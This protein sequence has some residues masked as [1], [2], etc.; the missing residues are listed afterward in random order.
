MPTLQPGARGVGYTVDMPLLIPVAL[1]FALF[2]LAL[3]MWPVTLWRRARRGH[4]RRRVAPWAVYVRSLM[5]AVATGLFGLVVALGWSGGPPR[6]AGLGLLAGLA[7][8]AVAAMLGRIETEGRAVYLTPSWGFPIAVALLVAG[9]VL[10]LAW[11]VAMGGGWA[12]ARRHAAPLGG[13]LVGYAFAQSGV[14][15]LRLRRGRNAACV[16]RR[17]ASG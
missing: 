4:M 13:L 8:G 2:A 10:W 17:R 7:V 12:E 14:L 1:L 5:L 9:R 16:A 6:E 15:A 11:D 3:L